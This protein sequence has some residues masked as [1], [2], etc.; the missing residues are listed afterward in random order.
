MMTREQL[1][2]AYA[3]AEQARVAAERA[4]AATARVIY[5]LAPQFEAAQ[6][7][8]EEHDRVIRYQNKRNARNEAFIE[9]VRVCG[10]SNCDGQLVLHANE[11]L[12]AKGLKVTSI[13][14]GTCGKTLAPPPATYLMIAANGF[15][16]SVRQM[17]GGKDRADA[18]AAVFNACH[19]VELYL[20]SLGAYDNWVDDNDDD[21]D[22]MP[23]GPGLLH[24][25]HDL[26]EL[27]NRASPYVIDRLKRAKRAV[28]TT[29]RQPDSAFTVATPC[30]RRA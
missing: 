29:L 15:Y 7:L 17:M 21:E 20:K 13:K 24:R 4:Y 9:K 14:C 22:E 23:D 27:L 1:E 28:S 26:R 3:Q 16:K 12:W 6:R 2:L 25:K 5:D 19:S 30:W 11:E 8:A 18:N 10:L